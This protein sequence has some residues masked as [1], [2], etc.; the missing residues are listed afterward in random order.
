MSCV[1]FDCDGVLTDSESIYLRVELAS[2]ARRGFAPERAGMGVAPS[3]CTIVEDSV[4]GDFAG[5]R[6]G[7]NVIGFTAG[8]HRPPG[9]GRVSLDAGA[10]RVVSSLGELSVSIG[11]CTVAGAE[12]G[13]R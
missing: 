1:V 11:A 5:R 4:N 2:L 7:M 12:A 10:E 9:H 8:S 3:T 13:R 6:A